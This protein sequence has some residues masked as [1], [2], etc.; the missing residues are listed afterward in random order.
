MNDVP[1]VFVCGGRDF[2]DE[3]TLA[4]ALKT[5][6][7]GLSKVIIVHGACPSGADQL[8]DDWGLSKRH[9]VKRFHADWS[10]HGKAAGPIRNAEM[11]DYLKTVQLVAAIVCW[12]G[13]SKGTADMVRRLD[14]AKIKY[15]LISYKGK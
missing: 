9:T 6:C 10:T 12:D 13:K 3:F 7:K 5:A 1:H 4:G 11:V 14:E 2:V 15:R 8:A